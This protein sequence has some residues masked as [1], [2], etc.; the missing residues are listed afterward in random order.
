[1]RFER[2]IEIVGDEPVFE[3][4]LLLAGEI[5]P[6]DVRRQL[7]RWT[8]SGRLYQVR[9]GLYALAPPF[10]KAKP[11][12][13][14]VANRLARGSYVSC[15]S[16]LAYHGLIPEYVPAV[17]SVTPSRP[18]RRCTPL[19]VY[20]YHHLRP[21]LVH[22]YRLLDVADRQ[23][24]YVATPEKALLDLVYLQPRGEQAAYVRELRLEN[25][26]SLDMDALRQQAVQ[27]GGPKLL[28]ASAALAELAKAVEEGY[29]AL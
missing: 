17:I 13:F 16:A 22:G 14:L 24:A 21:A 10:Q 26:S 15:Q 2:L 25:L 28:R 5:D 7:S 18:G 6:D 8:A 11:H 4:G 9:R 23:Q 3:A 19:G 29:E 12:P 20:Q 1:M 27:S